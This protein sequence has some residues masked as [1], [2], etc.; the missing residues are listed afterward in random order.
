[1]ALTLQAQTLADAAKVT[2]PLLQQ[3]KAHAVLPCSV[4]HRHTW[5]RLAVKYSCIASFLGDLWLRLT[6]LYAVL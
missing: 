1:M 5:L 6:C 3:F 4:Y 2:I